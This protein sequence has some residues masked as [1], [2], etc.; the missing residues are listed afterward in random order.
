ML[1]VTTLVLAACA[2]TLSDRGSRVRWVES[3]SEV[4]GCEWLAVVQGRSNYSD[5]VSNLSE[6]YARNDALNKAGELGAT[7]VLWLTVGRNSADAEAYRCPS[8]QQ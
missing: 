7:H 1:A 6:T 2:T 5:A 3:K 4:S 8:V